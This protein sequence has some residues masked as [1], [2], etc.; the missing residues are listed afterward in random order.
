MSA[1]MR[2]EF[3]THLHKALG[4]LNY[5]IIGGCALVEYGNRRGTSDIDLMVPSNVSEIVESQVLSARGFVRTAG[6]GIA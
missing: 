2:A 5:G 3:L 6:G 4:E 1:E